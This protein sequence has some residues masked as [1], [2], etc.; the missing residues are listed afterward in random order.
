MQIQKYV[1]NTAYNVMLMSFVNTEPTVQKMM[2][3]ACDI[4]HTIKNLGRFYFKN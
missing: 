4:N 2:M 3:N 1:H